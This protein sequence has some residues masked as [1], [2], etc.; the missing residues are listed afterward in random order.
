MVLQVSTQLAGRAGGSHCSSI[1]Q[2]LGWCHGLKSAYLARHVTELCACACRFPHSLQ[3]ALVAASAAVQSGDTF[4]ARTLL[5][6]LQQQQRTAADIPTEAVSGID[7]AESAQLMLAQLEAQ[8][9]RP[10]QV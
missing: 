5:S 3:A 8:E 4:K 6:Q 9:G 10:E 1:V 7:H 2:Q